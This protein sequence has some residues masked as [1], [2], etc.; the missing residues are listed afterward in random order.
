MQAQAQQL[1]GSHGFAILLEPNDA[2]LAPF[3]EAR[4]TVRCLNNMVGT[5]CDALRCAVGGLPVRTFGVCAGV[6]GSPVHVQAASHFI[7]G[8]HAEIAR[9]AALP[10][11]T[12]LRGVA[13][14][15]RFSV[16]NTCCFPVAV[17]LRVRA[18]QTDPAG[19]HVAAA[20]RPRP[21][22]SVALTLACACFSTCCDC[23]QFTVD[24]TQVLATCRATTPALVRVLALALTHYLYYAGQYTWTQPR[25]LMPRRLL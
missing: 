8:L 19:R 5:Y 13:V 23:H 14:R 1:L 22:G 11:G 17:R 7:P 24:C 9:T 15:K 25:H 3:G 21:D 16:R 4:I 18:H 6:V 2:V 10:F 12:A 20:L